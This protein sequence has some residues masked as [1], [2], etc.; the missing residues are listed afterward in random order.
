MVS[1]SSNPP[2]KSSA[3]AC[4]PR[5]D[6]D[7]DGLLGTALAEDCCCTSPKIESTCTHDGFC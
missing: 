2:N 1:G 7:D 3:G 4:G 6:D 5:C